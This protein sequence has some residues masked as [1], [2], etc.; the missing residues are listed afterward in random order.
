M[1]TGFKEAD[2]VVMKK[3][4]APLRR[5]ASPFAGRQPK[6]GTVFVEPKLVAEAEFLEWTRTAHPA[7]P[8]VQGAARR[9]GPAHRGARGP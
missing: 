5:D 8:L 2:L 6:K 9:Q 7:R 3:L 4:L 1:G